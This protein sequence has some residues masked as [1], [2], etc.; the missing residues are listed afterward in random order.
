MDDT[1]TPVSQSQPVRVNQSL[2]YQ[3]SYTVV[4]FCR[5]LSRLTARKRTGGA[6]RSRKQAAGRLQERM[7][8]Y[9]SLYLLTEILVTSSSSWSSSWSSLL[10]A[11]V[12]IEVS[13]LLLLPLNPR[14]QSGEHQ[15]SCDELLHWNDPLS[16]C[17]L[18]IP[19]RVN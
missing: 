7:S 15:L 3:S 16:L 13:V 18:L 17:G 5:S 9:I 4:V 19:G 6:G 1:D 8:R 2:C 10:P 14:L 12:S 11:H